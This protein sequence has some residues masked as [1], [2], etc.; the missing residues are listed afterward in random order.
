MKE[1]VVVASCDAYSACWQPF[2]SQFRRYWPECPYPVYLITGEKNYEG[3]DVRV[4]QT[5]KDAAWSDAMVD[6]LA[7]IRAH[8]VILLLEDY[9]LQRPVLHDDM[10]EYMRHMTAD[11]L[12]YLCLY[13]MWRPATP[14]GRPADIPEDEPYRASLQ[15]A[16][17]RA[18][19]LAGLCVKGEDPWQF[20]LNGTPRSAASGARF[21]RIGAGHTKDYPFDYIWT[22]IN[23]GK[24]HRDIKQ[25][26]E[27][28]GI[29]IDL[30]Y[31]PV[32]PKP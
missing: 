29:T 18:D 2:F 17:W 6:A 16:I 10:M 15:A 30:G 20:E 31:R 13:P 11:E 23:K 25:Y 22:G 5:G 1:A 7:R 24:W 4:V 19:V 27:T 9:F 26:C 21:Q 28:Q 32:E 3:H 8:H 14:D 12:G